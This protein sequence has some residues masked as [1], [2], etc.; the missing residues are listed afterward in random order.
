M[1]SSPPKRAASRNGHA[2]RSSSELLD[3]MPPAN[4]E[5][6]R[7]LVGAILTDPWR[8]SEVAGTLRPEHYYGAAWGTV[9]G[10]MLAVY[11]RGVLPDVVAVSG[12]LQSVP[13]P[14]KESWGVMLAEVLADGGIVINLREYAR[15]IRD[16]A[17]RREAIRAG[18]YLLQRGH[19]GR[20]AD[21]L[22]REV[23]A[24]ADRLRSMTAAPDRYRWRSAAQLAA[25]DL[26]VDWLVPGV[27]VAGQPGVIGAPLKTLKTSLALSLAVAL[28]LGERW[29][30]HWPVPRA[31]RVAVLSGE[32][33]EAT[34]RETLARVAA[35]HGR[36]L[37]DLG[38]LVVSPDLP[39][40]TEPADLAA[41]TRDLR[42]HEAELA[43]IDPL[44][45]VM[46]AADAGN[47]MAQGERLRALTEACLSVA[48]SPLVVHHTSRGA[49]ARAGRDTYEAP[50]LSDLA[51]AGCAEWARQWLLLGRRE[52][53]E[54]GTGLHRLW[55]SV[56]G[57]AGH[58]GCWSLTVD[59]GRLD[60]AGGRR[61]DVTVRSSIDEQRESAE[62]KERARAEADERR[63]AQH[64]EK[65]LS[66][67]R[68]HKKGETAKVLREACGLNS[69]NFR[70]AIDRLVADGRAEACEVTKNNRLETGYRPC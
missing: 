33:G 54:P 65:L 6:E 12:A 1:P 9:W 27:L 59:E 32:S 24:T 13:P 18:E 31:C 55:L 69:Q 2:R 34:V 61:W 43:I 52:R 42:G 23:A 20:S 4:V 25:A 14:G 39:R 68:R 11:Q 62:A 26:D 5:A 21:E 51:W 19:E 37:S 70:L 41:L 3:R 57:S 47:L 30:G 56:G 8:M 29:L 28:S 64:L 44:Y 7:A 48:V 17:T 67:L 40:V 46:P 22:V 16:A 58:S 36:K 63:D 10:A 15:Q 66:V 38:G 49:A 53:Y 60:D 50:E 35:A 45:L